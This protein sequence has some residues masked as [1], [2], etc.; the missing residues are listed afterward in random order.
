MREL[1]PGR[2]ARRA[3][4]Q[5]RQ[6]RHRPAGGQHR[7]RIAR[8]Q[9][10]LL[11]RHQRAVA[12]H[13]HQAAARG[14]FELVRAE[15]L[16]RRVSRHHEL[17]QFQRRR[18]RALQALA[19]DRILV[20][21][22][23]HPGQPCRQRHRGAL[24]QQAE[25]H[26]GE[27]HPE[28]QPRILHALQQREQRQHDRHRAA[29]AH[30]RQEPLLPPVEAERQQG[31]PDRHGPRHHHQEQRHGPSRQRHV[32]D[33]A[34]RDQ[35]AEQQEHHRL[36]QPRHA[37]HGAHG[38]VGH[39]PLAIADDH[40]GQVD[41]QE[42]AAV[43]RLDQR[44]DHAAGRADQD[45]LEALGH[46][47]ALHHP[48][49]AQAQHHAEHPTHAKLHHQTP[50]QRAGS[51]AVR[52][53]DPFDQRQGQEDRHGVIDAR[54]DLQHARHPLLEPDAAAV[55]QREHRGGVRRADDG[56]QQQAELPVDAE[57]PRRKQP[58]QHRRDAHPHRRQ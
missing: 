20:G 21:R 42:A 3:L 46:M 31:D 58:D 51:Q 25:Q 19:R 11:Q 1:R 17:H 57:H 22:P 16:H 49:H 55:E 35:Q 27:R 38:V 32:P 44:E 10:H 12:G 13:G 41:R 36:R 56:A 26:H 48:R 29:Q 30:P 15:V 8:A 47:D 6:Q 2:G 34:R 43:R 53:G 37:V 33:P 52:G 40:P 28:Q 14:E 18:P 50:R 9:H 23:Q 39:G 45:G 54:L 24:A 7:D 5:P 4:E